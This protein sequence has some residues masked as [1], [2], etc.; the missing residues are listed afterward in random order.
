MVQTCPKGCHLCMDCVK[1]FERD[2]IEKYQA[3]LNAEGL[4]EH[5]SWDF[6]ME[7]LKKAAAELMKFKDKKV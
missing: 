5:P 7:V 2:A 1:V 6:S 4:G 3:K